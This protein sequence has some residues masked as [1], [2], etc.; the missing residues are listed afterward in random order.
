MS[1][2]SMLNME[3]L[4]NKKEL[5]LKLFEKVGKVIQSPY[6]PSSTFSRK[7]QSSFRVTPLYSSD[8]LSNMAAVAFSFPTMGDLSSLL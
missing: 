5:Y 3:T 4:K 6:I 7:C 2:H 8:G 1:H